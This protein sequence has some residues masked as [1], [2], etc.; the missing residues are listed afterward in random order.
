MQ[1]L[2]EKLHKLVTPNTTSKGAEY[3]FI[4]QTI[5]IIFISFYTLYLLFLFNANLILLKQNSI[6][7]K[8]A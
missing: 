7:L 6:N 4:I 8:G 2:Q 1:C 5:H 3:V